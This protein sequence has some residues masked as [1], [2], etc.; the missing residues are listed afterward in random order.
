[1]WTHE[2]WEGGKNLGKRRRSRGWE[3]EAMRR[4]VCI[5]EQVDAVDIPFLPSL[6]FHLLSGSELHSQPS[7][8]SVS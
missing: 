5:P 7:N 4:K 2:E 6:V 8:S 3:S 1:M